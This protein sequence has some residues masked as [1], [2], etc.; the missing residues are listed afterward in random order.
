MNKRKLSWLAVL[1]VILSFSMVISFSNA[2]LVSGVDENAP[3]I[4][5]T[6]TASTKYAPEQ[7]VE[8]TKESSTNYCYDCNDGIHHKRVH[9]KAV[10]DQYIGSLYEFDLVND[11]DVLH[12]HHQGGQ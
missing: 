5:S 10:Y 8:T 4:S 3:T 9:D 11:T 12:I 6:T 1:V 7:P 2:A